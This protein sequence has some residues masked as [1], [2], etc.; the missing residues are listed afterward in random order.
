MGDCGVGYLLANSLSS[1]IFNSI[2]FVRESF[3]G[4]SSLWTAVPCYFLRLQER[5]IFS[6]L[7]LLCS[8]LFVFIVVFK[9]S[10]VFA[11]CNWFR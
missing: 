4:M 6:S 8:A 11:L 9:H 7:S 5:Y 1:F 3:A 10:Y 2:G